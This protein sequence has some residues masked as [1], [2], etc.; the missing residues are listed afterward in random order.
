MS[1]LSSYISALRILPYTFFQSAGS[2]VYR[3]VGSD[4]YMM[5]FI[6]NMCFGLLNL[7]EKD[8]KGEPSS[9]VIPT[10]HAYSLFLCPQ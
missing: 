4:N 2:S 1:A 6:S 5:I 8:R 3:D 9:I 10:H 7:W